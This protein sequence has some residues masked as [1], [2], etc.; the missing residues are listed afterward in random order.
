MAVLVVGGGGAAFAN[1]ALSSAYSPTRATLDYFAAQ[2]RGDANTMAANATFLHANAASSTLFDKTA[3]AAMLR[4]SENEQVSD[5]KVV[6]TRDVDADNVAVSVSMK[7]AGKD[8][9]ATYNVK[10]DQS[11]VHYFLYPSWRIDIPSIKISIGLPN[12]A[13]AVTV[14]GIITLGTTVDAIAGY[15]TVKLG[16]TSFYD[17]DS[18][19]V[20]GVDGDASVT[21]GG[22]V[23]DSFKN[24]VS[25]EVKDTF[26]NHCDATKNFD[27]PGHKYTAPND[28]YIYFLRMPGHPEIDYTTYLFAFTSDPT[29]SM[30]ITIGKASGDV[31]AVGSCAVTLTV[32]GSHKYNFKGTWTAAMTYSG[33]TF[34]KTDI[35]YDC[36]SA[37]A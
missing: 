34:S 2:G 36:E 13:T 37:A 16:R 21:I 26:N 6:S 17:E 30:T 10:K 3:L 27:C 29:A 20:N 23:S 28:G 25:V 22:K 14:D 9:T 12:Q 1:F 11:N 5:V 15:H 8:R 19:V 18:E 32:D 31:T 33:S 35:S 24:A 7:W 4:T